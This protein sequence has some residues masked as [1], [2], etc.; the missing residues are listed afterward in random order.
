MYF[1]IFSHVFDDCNDLQIKHIYFWNESILGNFGEQD[2]PQSIYPSNNWE[3]TK[4]YARISAAIATYIT[5]SKSTS[6]HLHDY[7]LGFIPFYLRADL[8]DYSFVF[9]IHNGSYQGW[10][11]IWDDP[12]PVM[13][14]LALSNDSYYN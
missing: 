1:E 13:Y 10:L 12:S 9:T 3:A 2:I 11:E 6:I 5:I 7:H 4:I 8:I 14:E